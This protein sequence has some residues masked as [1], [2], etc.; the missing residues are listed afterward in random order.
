METKSFCVSFI[1]FFDND[2]TS[3]VV[4]AVSELDA[5]LLYLEK[6]QNFNFYDKIF[7]DLEQLKQFCFNCDCMINAIEIT[8]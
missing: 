8:N 5:A 4:E 7:E 2:L 6:Y 3:K 1:N